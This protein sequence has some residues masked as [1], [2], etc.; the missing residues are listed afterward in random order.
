MPN[1]SKIN[2][3]HYCNTFSTKY[4]I[5]SFAKKNLKDKCLC[6]KTWNFNKANRIWTN[7]LITKPKQS[8][9]N[10]T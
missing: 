7:S 8:Y 4:I 3:D 2:I 6:W 9:I 10:L 5:F 1:S